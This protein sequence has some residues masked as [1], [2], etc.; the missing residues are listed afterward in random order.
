MHAP[1]AFQIRPISLEY[2]FEVDCE[3]VL[4]QPLRCRR[5]FD[6]ILAAA[7]VSRDLDAEVEIYDCSGAL[8]ETLPLKPELAD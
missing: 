1:F 3:G 8:V 6:A 7:H 5:L 2:G 4:G